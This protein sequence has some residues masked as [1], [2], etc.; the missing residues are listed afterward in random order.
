MNPTVI[1]DCKKFLFSEMCLSANEKIWRYGW[2]RR[3]KWTTNNF[4][5]FHFFCRVTVYQKPSL[6]VE[7]ILLISF[8][9]LFILGLLLFLSARKWRNMK[10]IS[11]REK[12]FLKKLFWCKYVFFCLEFKKRHHGWKLDL[13]SRIALDHIIMRSGYEI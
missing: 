5:T 9:V 10:Y 2:T 13:L 3:V 7:E 4:E 11:R 1:V 6:K 12:R 8:A